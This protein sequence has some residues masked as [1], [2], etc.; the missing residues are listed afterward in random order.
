LRPISGFFLNSE[1][2]FIAF[3]IPGCTLPSTS[4]GRFTGN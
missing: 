1:A 4:D 2:F 3:G